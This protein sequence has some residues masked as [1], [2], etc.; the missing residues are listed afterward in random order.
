MQI[1]PLQ[2]QSFVFERIALDTSPDVPEAYDEAEAPAL[3]YNVE[4]I[5]S[6]SADEEGVL[7]LT[8]ML[9]ADQE[10]WSIYKG[11]ISVV[12]RFVWIDA[13]DKIP[14]DHRDRYYLASGFSILYGLLRGL[15]VQL[16][17]SSPHPGLLLP[18]LDFGHAVEELVH[19]KT[20][21]ESDGE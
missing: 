11:E 14:P 12:G 2:L 18:S 8:L 15:A 5:R 13:G 3:R 16:T 20:P 1:A 10:S 21:P 4:W 19:S 7:R 17:A 9:N 6:P